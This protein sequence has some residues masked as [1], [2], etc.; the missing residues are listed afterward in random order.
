MISSS[1]S[2]KTQIIGVEKIPAN[3]AA[4]PQCCVVDRYTQ[5]LLNFLAFNPLMK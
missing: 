3:V 2:E 1:K 4:Q 5:Q